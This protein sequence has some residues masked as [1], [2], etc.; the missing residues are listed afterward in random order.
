MRLDGKYFK[1]NRLRWQEKLNRSIYAK[2]LVRYNLSNNSRRKEFSD[3]LKDL[4]L[5]PIQDS[6]FYGDL[7]LAEVRA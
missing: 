3:T 2:N 6:V 1:K 5:V 7:K 4:G